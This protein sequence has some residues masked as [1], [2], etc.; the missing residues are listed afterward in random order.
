LLRDGDGEPYGIAT[1][2]HDL[3]GLR[4]A[5]QALTRR[6]AVF[7]ALVVRASDL[8][9]VVDADAR[10]VYVSPAVTA[11]IGYRAEQM[12]GHAGWDFVHP[13]DTARLRR[14]FDEVA[15]TAGHSLTEVFRLLDAT[16]KWL[17]V[18]EVLTNCL[19]DPDI[20]GIVCNL[21][22]VT[23]RVQAETA[24]RESEARYRAIAETA[25]EGIWTFDPTGRT[26]YANGQ[27][28]TI[29]GVELHEVYERSVA[30]L[31]SPD[32]LA[33]DKL[34]RSHRSDAEQYDLTYPHPD[35]GARVLH[36]NV[37]P[38]R[39][40][41]GQTG[42]LATLTDVTG[43]RR[44]EQ[45]LTR[46]ALRDELTGVANRTLLADRMEQALARATRSSFPVAVLFLG[47]D[48]FKLINDSCGQTPSMSP[49]ACWPPWPSPST[50]PASASTCKPASASRSR[51]RT[52]HRTCCASLRPQ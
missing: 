33:A 18:E 39:D 17:W 30:E 9:M 42:S 23:A 8:A 52:R 3:T 26:M 43:A 20:G 38:L 49:T 44:A 16:G 51:L 21:R 15:A 40:D 1:F 4:Q 22:D 27:L 13:D 34:Q 41:T 48:Q 2:L 28:A 5:E 35:G 37:A 12:L 6:D 29:L 31:L 11:T 47:L 45:E 46:R 50:S 36:L 25:Q 10:L 7:K 14:V 32:A 19:D 24:L